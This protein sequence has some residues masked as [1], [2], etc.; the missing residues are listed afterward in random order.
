MGVA[1][2][3][4]EAFFCTLAM[5]SYNGKN[6]IGTLNDFEDSEV[7]RDGPGA[8]LRGLVD[9]GV[10]TFACGQIEEG[11]ETHHRHFH[12][13]LQLKN[14]ARLSWMRRHV[15]DKAHWE[16]MRGTAEQAR[17]YCT[18][19]D[20]RVQGPWS[21]GTLTRKGK[22][23][24]LNE[25]IELVQSGAPMREV[26]ERYPAVWVHHGRGLTDLRQRLG[27]EC[28]RRT[29]GP[30]GPE[31]WLLWGPSGSGKSRFVS[32]QWPDA[33]WKLSGEKWWDGYDRHET[34]ILDDFKDGELRLTDLQHLLDRYPL[35]VEVKGG[36]VPMLA[37]RYVI[38]SNTHCE[39]WYRKSD[40]HRTIERRI[41]DYAEIHARVLYCDVGWYQEHAGALRERISGQCQLQRGLGNTTAEA[42]QTPLLRDAFTQLMEELHSE[43]DPSEVD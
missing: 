4:F 41:H 21:Y 40:P 7:E 34:V 25:A 1:G 42:D 36:A 3:T 10:C 2:F 18:K 13:F 29:F 35:W 20:T 6:W 32:E 17:E 28:D 15:N 33:Y 11:D 16:Q 23:G 5:T 26:I 9:S 12:C 30:E 24:G 27:L 14:A 43:S 22:M 31:V 8:W 39:E 37:K 38:T 19:V